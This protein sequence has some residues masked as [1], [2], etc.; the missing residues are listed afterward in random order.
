LVANLFTKKL[1]K[2]SAY[3]LGGL[4]LLLVG[5]HFWFMH[6]AK[7]LL[8][9]LVHEQSNGKLTLRIEKFKFNWF[10]RKMEL[11]KAVF[12]STDTATASTAYRFKVD[13][14]KIQVK[15][16]LPVIM[17]KRF[18]IDSI[19][20]LNPDITVTRLRSIRD[21]TA[22][23]DTSLSIPQE[24]GRIYH[25]IQD[26]LEVLEV[27]RFQIDNG[28]FSLIN[29][30]DPDEKPIVISRLYFH[31]DNLHVADSTSS[32]S[33]KKI[34]FSDNVA[35]HT[36]NQNII[37]PD[38]RHQLSFSNFRINI[39]N[40]LA[41]FDSCTIMASKGDSAKTSFRIFFDKLRMT[42][43]DFDTLYHTEVI[44][45]DSVYCINPRFRL[46]VDLEKRTGPVKPPKL[47]ELIQQLTGNLQLAF[48]VVQNASFDIN[49]IR[50]GR[51][52]SFTSDHNNFEL[53][54]LRIQQDAPRPLTV[55]RFA[56]A[57]RN[58]ENFLR[59][60]AYAIQFDSVHINNSRISLNNFSYQESRKKGVINSLM[61]PQFEL[62]GLSW[63]E[64]IFD[65]QLKAERVSLYRPVINYTVTSNNN[66]SQNVFE[67]LS[68]IGSII[69]LN[70]LDITD[71]QVNLFFPNQTKLQLDGATMSLSARDLVG[72]KRLSG[73]QR[74]IHELRFRK[75]RFISPGIEANLENVRFN[76][77]MNGLK[78]S[79]IQV[80]GE[81]DLLINGQDITIGSMLLDD[82]F[83]LTTV[84]GISWKQADV[85]LSL[86]PSR[87]QAAGG[88]RLQDINGNNTKFIATQ[89]SKKIEVLLNSMK[90]Q[91]FIHIKTEPVRLTGLVA[92]GNNLK[93]T[94]NGMNLLVKSLTLA[95]HQA[96]TFNQLSYRNIT[97]EDSMLV[98]IPSVSLVPD[99][100]AIINGKIMVDNIKI[101]Q[102]LVRL[103]L[104]R[105]SGAPAQK[106]NIQP[107]FL[108]SL[109]IQ[110]PT[111]EFFSTNEKGNAVLQWNG[112]DNNN[113]IA[114]TNLKVNND[115]GTK[116]ISADQL[117]F[118]MD[119]F[120]YTDAKGK[121][122]DAKDGQ[123]TAR[124]DQLAL[125]KNEG[126][127]WEWQGIISNLA[128]KNFVIDSLGKKKGTLRIASASL[129][130]LSIGSSLLL[131][132]RE[133]VTQNE[134]FNLKEVT[135]NYHDS[136][137]QYNWYNAGYDKKTKSFSV[138]SFS[139]R[140]TLEQ[141]AFIKAQ[142]Y[143]SDYIRAR[144]GRID[145]GPF[146]LQRFTRD[147]ILDLGV[148][149][150]YNGYMT[151]FRDKRVPREPGSIG[152]L[153]VNLL[154]KIPVKVLVDTL[155]IKDAHIEYEE[156]NEK[157]QTGGKIIVS[158]LNGTATRIRNFN[159][160]GSDSLYIRA[161][162]YLQDTLFTKLVVKESYVDS[163]SGFLMTVQMGPADLTVFNP[164]LLPLA[165]AQL[166]SGQLDSMTMRVVGREYIAFGEMQMY[167]RNLKVRVTPKD[168]RTFLSG[169]V[170]FLAN[171]LI[172]NENKKRIGTVFFE[173]LRDRSAINYLVKIT[174]SGISSSVGV[175]SNTKQLKKYDKQIKIKD[176][177]PIE[178]F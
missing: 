71:G 128:A 5:F 74:S 69:Q 117:R 173:R 154:K 52:S 171:T 58:Y 149:D 10:S 24:M 126:E 140:P 116:N 133:L 40:K 21:T 15:M 9:D 141:N 174:L 124:I 7:D 3:I 44:K 13:R 46:D 155:N 12:Y 99:I 157:T 1:T 102:P 175:K 101:S 178:G 32:N 103:N 120:Q 84:R 131:N 105:S 27:D 55:E 95:D 146:D 41:E 106:T 68:G 57:I 83:Q 160:S 150:L 136:E 22:I 31:L 98:N 28:T 119:H 86:F 94:D 169:L 123:L 25:S 145:I 92:N 80:K 147:T 104:F 47:N 170:T 62:Q 45:A 130:D 135:G 81:H 56:M 129:N 50:E 20:L 4:V 122:F 59:D 138:D 91:E 137:D 42:N 48:V 127:N 63:D 30:M 139:Y 75:G 33:N 118:S 111:I 158:R 134:R 26:A 79:T 43:I 49:T 90:A 167:Y 132:M 18:L 38:G 93:I 11:Q 107:V 108:G 19:H 29:K 88:I 34:L 156:L 82:Q 61:M 148:I 67:I 151:D 85:R 51:L 60:S 14:L 77:N 54:G 17:E 6:H 87:G 142:R 115:G 176:L 168:K 16:I 121:T 76:T 162:A 153:P 165:S 8:E 23:E 65:Q 114:I 78:A 164:V 72:S 53:Q 152:E 66:R 96:S 161:S 39:Q 109:L 2:I 35:L 112:K 113:S 110:Q 177:P 73:I 70:D 163:L 166:K 143:Q 144:T 64:L 159:F 125:Q 37:F 89:G 97:D 100:N 36:S 172:R